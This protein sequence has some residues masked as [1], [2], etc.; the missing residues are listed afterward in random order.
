MHVPTGVFSLVTGLFLSGVLIRLADS[1]TTLQR[2][3]YMS[4][5]RWFSENFFIA[6][7]LAFPEHFRQGDLSFD[8]LAFFGYKESDWYK[9]IYVPIIVGTHRPVYVKLITHPDC[10]VTEGKTHLQCTYH[11]NSW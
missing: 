7:Y 8:W 2:I 3:T 4:H 11:L 10:T 6:E 9:G 5:G 1:S